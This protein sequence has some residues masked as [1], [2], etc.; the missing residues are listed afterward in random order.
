VAKHVLLTGFEP[1]G[2]HRVNPSELPVRSLEGRT[3]GGRTVAV[4]VER[5]VLKAVGPWLQSRP[6]PV[7]AARANPNQMW[8]HRGIREVER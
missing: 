7:R 6:A 5:F 3:I 1:F 4:R 2:D 8:I